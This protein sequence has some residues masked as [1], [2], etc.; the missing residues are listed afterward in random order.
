MGIGDSKTH[1]LTQKV[2]RAAVQATLD[3]GLP[4]AEES[5]IRIAQKAWAVGIHLV[6]ATQRP[7]ADGDGAY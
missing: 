4:S 6:L 5:I 3:D 2:L 1:K 7:S